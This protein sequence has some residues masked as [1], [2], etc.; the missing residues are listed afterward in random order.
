MSFKI[1]NKFYQQ[2]DHLFS[3]SRSSLCFSE[4]CIQRC[5]EISIYNMIHNPRAFL[6]KVDDVFIITQQDKKH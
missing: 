4:I 6:R 1:S 3:G 2:V 5:E